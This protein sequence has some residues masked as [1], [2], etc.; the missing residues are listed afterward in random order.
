MLRGILVAA[1]VVAICPAVARGETRGTLRVG[2]APVDLQASPETPLFGAE[3][4]QAVA[5]YNAA[6]AAF[7]QR[8]GG[9]MA[10]IAA[11]DLSLT[12]TLVVLAPGLELADGHYLFRI[13][14][15]IGLADDLRSVGLGIY[16]I[17]VQG[18]LRRDVVA[19][20]SAGGAVSWLDRPGAGDLGGMIAARG[21]VGLR[22]ANHITGELGYT[23]YALGGNLNRDRLDQMA[24]DELARLA[25]DDLIAAGEAHGMLDVS[26]GVAF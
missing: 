26:L 21:V 25:P 4:D 10:R 18:K 19:Y 7:E 3:L 14:A 12:E 13:E 6:A 15:P 5:D 8:H 9:Q 17:G 16:P 2:L 1:S 24:I 11:G 23:A 20:A 22:F